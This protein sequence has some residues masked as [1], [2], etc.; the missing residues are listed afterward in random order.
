MFRRQAETAVVLK[1]E[2]GAFILV[3]VGTSS[4]WMNLYGDAPLEGRALTEAL[5]QVWDSFGLIPA[6]TFQDDVIGE[7]IW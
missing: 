5:S 1:A 3:Q 2:R 7:I 6:E 4:P